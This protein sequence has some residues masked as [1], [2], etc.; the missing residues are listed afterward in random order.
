MQLPI[1]EQNP[2]E[3]QISG[4]QT[5]NARNLQ[6][7]M[8]GRTNELSSKRKKVTKKSAEL[9][10]KKATKIKGLDAFSQPK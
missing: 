7:S 3:E 6:S 2:Q 1:D 5:E 8:S 9:P 4:N 10:Q